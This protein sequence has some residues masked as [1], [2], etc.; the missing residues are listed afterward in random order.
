MQRRRAVHLVNTVSISTQTSEDQNSLHTCTSPILR[1]SK[2]GRQ[3][4]SSRTTSPIDNKQARQRSTSLS[5]KSPHGALVT[6]PF[7]I[8]TVGGAGTPSSQ[9]QSPVLISSS[10]VN[11]DFDNCHSTS[12]ISKLNTMNFEDLTTRSPLPLPP[13]PPPPP[14]PPPAKKIS[15][16]SPFPE[17]SLSGSGGN[18]RPSRRSS[19]GTPISYKEPSLKDKIR[20][21]HKYFVPVA[22][23]T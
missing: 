16:R 22:R 20:K 23:G 8:R 5:S 17:A 4:T 7:S 1:V 12:P 18:S 15:M 3:S 6:S 19:V 10:V 11:L 2:D 14:F 21:G 9:R 13:P